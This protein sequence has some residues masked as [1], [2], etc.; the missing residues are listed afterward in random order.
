MKRILIIDDNMQLRENTEALLE[1]AGYQVKTAASGREGVN[2]AQK[3]NPD[4]I[5]CDIMMPHMDGYDVLKE[6]RSKENSA[7]TPFIFLTAL[8]QKDEVRKGMNMGA[9]DYITKPFEDDELIDAIECRLK[10]WEFLKREFFKN[11]QGINSFFKEASQ[12]VKLETLNEN[13]DLEEFK[14]KEIIF[15]EG[16]AA[17]QLYFIHSGNI[18]TFRTT[19]GGKEF[20]T[21]IHGP[22]EFFGQLSLLNK[23]GRYIETAMVLKDAQVFHISKE[24]F[25]TLLHSNNEISNKFIE[26]ISN[27]LLDVQEKL[28][29]MA[30]APVRQRAAKALLQLLTKGIGQDFE[31]Q[32]ISIPRED[33][34]AIIGTATETAIRTLSEF[35]EEG[36]IKMDIN[37]RII[38]LD[39]EELAGIADSD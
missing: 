5:L 10:K 22:G 28:I 11:Y 6:V 35:K 33:F 39:K 19:K 15:R 1:L 29:N 23:K 37:R 26:V 36:L 16:M 21:G 4:L 38:I 13:R 9:D 30:Y 25:N 20:V 24:E 7:G 31:N 3:F 27:N 12:Y 17:N 14:A 34:A 8:A 32:A 18:K 2:L